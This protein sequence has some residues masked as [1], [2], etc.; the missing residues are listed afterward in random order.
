[1]N[2]TLLLTT[3][4]F[5]YPTLPMN[6]SLTDAMGQ[7]FTKG[8]DIFTVLSHSHCF[9]THLLAQNVSWPSVVL[10]YPRWDDFTREIEKRYPYLGISAYPVHLNIVM[11][12]CEHVR[13]ASPA[14]KILLGSYAA[15]AFRAVYDEQ[16]QK[17]Y[18]DHVVVGDGIGFLR[19]LLGDPVDAPV[20]QHLFPKAGA[21]SPGSPRHSKGTIGFLVSGLGCAGGCDFCSTTAMFSNRRT[22]MLSSDELFEGIQR[23]ART[24]PEVKM[25][26]VVEE[27]HFRVPNHLLGLRERWQAEPELY[28]KL[29]LFTFGSVDT[30]AQFAARHGWDAILEAGIGCIF[31]G[32]ESKLAGKN[33]YGKRSE[34]EAREVSRS[35]TPSASARWERGCAASTGTIARTSA[36][37]SVTSSPFGPPTS[38]SP[39]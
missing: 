37:T 21:R 14:T 12:M 31:I 9:G 13:K 29:D 19:G 1:M 10:E 16:K 22:E 38:S 32:V 26:F 18:V 20:R 35:S 27:D 25:I 3:P 28:G 24:S 30:I 34:A 33:G 8:D 39:G 17:Q 23:Y 2:R 4:C 6:D 15:Q 11:R 36:K 5:P 7:R